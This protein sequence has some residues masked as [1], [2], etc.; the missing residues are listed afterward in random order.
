MFICCVAVQFS[1]VTEVLNNMP[2]L[3]FTTDAFMASGLPAWW[4]ARHP[5]AQYGRKM[6][7]VLKLIGGPGF[8]LPFHCDINKR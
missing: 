7:V 8:S 3:G 2:A 1:S 4:F 6:F 5:P